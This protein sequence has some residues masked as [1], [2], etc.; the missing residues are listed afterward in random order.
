[1]WVSLRRPPGKQIESKKHGKCANQT[2]EKV[3]DAGANNKRKKEEFALRSKN[4]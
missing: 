3:E 2:V 1:L 4:R